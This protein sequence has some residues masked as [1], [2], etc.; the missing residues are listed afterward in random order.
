MTFKVKADDP[1]CLR[2]ASR[3]LIELDRPAQFNNEATL[4]AWAQVMD[5]LLKAS[6]L[7]YEEFRWFLIWACRDDEFGNHWTA[8]NLRLANDPAASLERQFETTLKVFNAKQRVVELLKG[9]REEEDLHAK[10]YA[11][12]SLVC[13]YCD[14]GPDGERE[15][16]CDDCWQDWNQP[17]DAMYDIDIN[18]GPAKCE[19]EEC[20]GHEY[21]ETGLCWFHFCNAMDGVKPFS[22]K[23][24]HE[25]IK[26]R[27]RTERAVQMYNAHVCAPNGETVTARDL[28]DWSNEEIESIIWLADL[29]RDRRACMAFPKSAETAK[30]SSLRNYV[31]KAMK[32][33]TREYVEQTHENGNS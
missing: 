29:N 7:D 30:F 11:P 8:E 12:L 25:G 18:L 21:G 14:Y 9:K 16:W 15:K 13:P 19:V 26:R 23:L 28:L 22:G 3:F 32:E 33:V 4:K 20:D 31:E 1:E 2:L 17:D 24:D 27:L 10:L 5:R 6:A